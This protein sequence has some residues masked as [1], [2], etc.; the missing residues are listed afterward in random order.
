MGQTIGIDFGTT[1]TIVSYKNKKGKIICLR[2][3]GNSKSIPT[4]LAF[5]SRDE[6][7]Y[8]SQALEIAERDIIEP[9]VSFKSHLDE[10][11][12][13]HVKDNDGKEFK[14]SAQKAVKLFI[15]SIVKSVQDRIINHFGAEE[16]YIDKAIITVPAKFSH[17]AKNRILQAAYDAGLAR[18]KLVCEP[19]AA[20]AAAFT[21]MDK[22]ESTMLVYDFGG[23][24]FDIS[25][26][27]ARRQ[28][29]K[30]KYD[31]LHTSGQKT[32]GGNDITF[33]IACDILQKINRE[34]GL[35][36][37]LDDEA[38]GLYRILDPD[39]YDGDL[40]YDHYYENAKKIIAAAEDVKIRCSAEGSGEATLWLTTE[41]GEQKFFSAEYDTRA[42]EMIINP[43]ISHTIEITRESLEWAK[44]NDVHLD[45]VVL[46]GGSSNIPMIHRK[47]N[48]LVGYDIEEMDGIT[49]LISKGAVILGEHLINE[50]S[51]ITSCNY[52]I[53]V[54][55]DNIF[56]KFET[57][58]PINTKL[59]STAEKT[60]YLN[61]DNQKY[62]EIKLYE[63]D[64]QNYPKST[65]SMHPGIEVDQIYQ[66]SLPPGLR[67]AD[68][69]LKLSFEFGDDSTVRINV[70]IFKG[71]ELIDSRQG[72]ITRDDDLE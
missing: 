57:L 4:A 19:T 8:G 30:T 25:I 56:D 10:K 42:F 11:Y 44:E 71:T 20:A 15:S 59:P 46:A 50:V 67:R 51:S 55:E 43:T 31:Q 68:T 26:V 7:V 61:E 49:E 65:R 28:N 54:K 48:D 53:I 18:V 23:G 45:T 24:T 34:F 16:G 37:D 52:G 60:Y 58:I 5:T 33:L 72:V 32:L 12:F 1:N 70:K 66:I 9:I 64:I 22:E 41:D 14:I 40:P 39:S 27:S 38:T 47:L 13:Y 17:N 63:H 3:S 2:D 36:M 62:L 21:A 35:D 29:G 69:E 6:Y